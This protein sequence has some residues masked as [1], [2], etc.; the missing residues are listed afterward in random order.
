[1]ILVFTLLE[2]LHV[3]KE[4][5]CMRVRERLIYCWILIITPLKNQVVVLVWIPRWPIHTVKHHSFIIYY[6]IYNVEVCIG[7]SIPIFHEHGVWQYFRVDVSWSIWYRCNFSNS[8]KVIY[9]GKCMYI[10]YKISKGEN[11]LVQSFHE[12]QSSILF[13]GIQV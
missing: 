9:I 10:H 2:W 8:R 7:Y 11:G 5:Y 13:S 3:L 6:N 1:M 12:N 4:K